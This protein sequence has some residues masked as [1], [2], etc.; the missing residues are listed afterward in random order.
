MDE[1]GIWPRF[2]VRGMYDRFASFDVKVAFLANDS[3][4]RG[5][6]SMKAYM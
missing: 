3:C 1:I 6:Q 5:S 2:R 4:L